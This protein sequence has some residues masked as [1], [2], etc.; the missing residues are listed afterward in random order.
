MMQED[1][2]EVMMAKR[3]N[4]I[5]DLEPPMQEHHKRRKSRPDEGPSMR[6]CTKKTMRRIGNNDLLLSR[7]QPEYS[8]VGDLS[9]QTTN[10]TIGQLIARCL[11]L[12]RELRQGVSTRRPVEP[13]EVRTTD[14]AKGDLKSPQVEA[15]I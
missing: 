15:Y 3:A 5:Q 7:D 6:E 1:V 9:R 14:L 2:P 10:I 12:R 4:P 13:V 8:I 11:S